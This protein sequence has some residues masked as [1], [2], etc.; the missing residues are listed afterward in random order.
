MKNVAT[1]IREVAEHAGVSLRTA[2]N[3]INP[4]QRHLYAATTVAR[5]LA[6]ADALG[7]RPN[8]YAK[9]LMAG[10]FGAIGLLMSTISPQSSLPS[11]LLEGIDRGL[12]ARNLHLTLARYADTDLTDPQRVPKLLRELLCDGL[13]VNYNA[14][15]PTGLHDLLVAHRLPVVWVN[16]KRPQ[17]SV[18]PDDYGGFAQLTRMLI[19]KGHRHIAYLD[20][21][22]AIS[23]ANRHQHFSK[24]DRLAGVSDTCREAGVRCTVVCE[25]EPGAKLPESHLL[26]LLRAVDRPTAWVSYAGE[27]DAVLMLA[28]RAGIDLTGVAILN[29]LGDGNTPRW[30]EL[31]WLN[32]PEKSMG[33]AAVTMIEQA[34]AAPG[35]PLPSQVIPY[36][37]LHLAG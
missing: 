23:L 4:N 26:Q 31:S 16:S 25:I 11:A 7:Y 32:V 19:E 18:H 21:T 5:I 27:G 9:A 29:C 28:A 3:V 1:T 2:Q 20:E 34:I 30:P 8:S 12:A 22:W 13:L 6:A 14:G 35:K 36:T 17:D 24:P 33:E 10:R 37:S 15:V